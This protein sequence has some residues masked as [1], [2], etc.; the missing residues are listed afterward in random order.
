VSTFGIGTE[1]DEGVWR[2]VFRQLIAKGY[3]RVDDY[4][5]LRLSDTAGAVLKGNERLMLRREAPRLAKASRRGK[6]RGGAKGKGAATFKT[7]AQSS[8]YAALAK[9]RM[10]LAKA[11]NLPS[12]C[13]F[14]NATLDEMARAQP[15][16]LGELRGISGVGDVKLEKYGE[17]F[18]RIIEAWR[19]SQSAS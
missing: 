19:N 13:I 5:S 12:Y 2:S 15:A 9:H 4:G 6:S 7:D 16:T 18:L 14:Q 11:A 3:A 8:L 1:H 17:E 10:A